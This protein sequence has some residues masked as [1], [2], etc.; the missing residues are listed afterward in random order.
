MSIRPMEGVVYDKIP[1]RNVMVSVSEKDGLEYLVP[2]LLEKNPD[3][4]FFSTGGTYRELKKILGTAAADHL[5]PVESYTGFPEMKGGLVKTLHPMIHSG[6]LGE[7]SN[8]EHL[9]YIKNLSKT[10]RFI[11]TDVQRVFDAE[12]GKEYKVECIEG[13]NCVYFD[14]LVLNLYPFSQKIAEESATFEDARGNIDIGGPS[15]LRGGAKNFLSCAVVCDPK[16]YPSLLETMKDGCTTYDQRLGFAEKA[17]D[18]TW[19]YDGDIRNY[20]KEQIRTNLEGIKSNYKF[21]ERL[22]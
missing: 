2:G 4:M 7:R 10:L 6:I 19:M 8:P 13:I 3:C 21:V 15:M 11:D 20:F 22:E 17:F 1:V 12:V 14:M 9:D 18:T 16:D 5:I